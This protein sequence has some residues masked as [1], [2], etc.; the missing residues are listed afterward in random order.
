MIT[1][2]VTGPELGLGGSSD[3]G[4]VVMNTIK[5]NPDNKKYAYRFYIMVRVGLYEIRRTRL[6]AGV[7]LLLQEVAMHF[8]HRLILVS[9]STPRNM[10]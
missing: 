6:R 4:F 7:F 8:V 2:S 9:L 10:K 5:T 1:D 3:A